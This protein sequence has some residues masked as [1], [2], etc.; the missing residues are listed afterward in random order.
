M[1]FLW[2]LNKIDNLLTTINN[3]TLEDRLKQSLRTFL[4]THCWKV[5][6]KAIKDFEDHVKKNKR[7]E[8]I[9]SS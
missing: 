7:V 3:T 8:D 2:K 5:D 1:T 9:R 4:D 6:E